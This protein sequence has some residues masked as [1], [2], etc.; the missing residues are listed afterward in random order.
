MNNINRPQ[1]DFLCYN[2]NVKKSR[3]VKY[4]TWFCDTETMTEANCKGD[5]SPVLIICNCLETDEWKTFIDINTYMEWLLNIGKYDRYTIFFHNLAFDGY[6]VIYWLVANKV[7]FDSCIN[8]TSTIFSIKVGCKLTFKCTLNYLGRTMSI[9]RLGEMFN[10]PKGEFDYNLIRRYQTLDEVPNKLIVYCRR[11]IEIMKKG[12]LTFKELYSNSEKLTLG[13]TS[14]NNFI[15]MIG[16]ISFKEN[17]KNKFFMGKWVNGKFIKDQ[18]LMSAWRN[19]YAGGLVVINPDYIN[20]VV[21]KEMKHYDA[22]SMYPSQMKLKWLPCGSLSDSPLSGCRQFVFHLI[23]YSKFKLRNRNYIPHIRDPKRST[24]SAVYLSQYDGDIQQLVLTDEEYKEIMLSYDGNFTIIRSWY[25]KCNQLLKEYIEY[26]E[27]VKN[28][29]VPGSPQYQSA[30]DMMNSL[31]GKFAENPVKIMKEVN[32][33]GFNRYGGVAFIKDVEEKSFALDNSYLPLAIAIASLGRCELVRN[34]RKL[35]DAGNTYLYCDTDSIIYIPN[36][37]SNDIIKVGKNF[38][39]WK[40]ER[41]NNKIVKF[42][43]IRPKCYMY[44]LDNGE[45]IIKISGVPDESKYDIVD[46][47]KVYKI[48]FDNF[49]SGLVLEKRNKMLIKGG[50]VIVNVNFT[51]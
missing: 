27:N 14:F 43:A 48:N 39:E 32:R 11:D 21:N 26:W 2:D 4:F 44:Q 3:Q 29:S 46:G 7:D 17:Y 41:P 47:K 16:P 38:G 6:A 24:K 23:E 36:G 9:K 19:G 33:E 50:V 30:K 1:G 51:I 12:Y 45:M 22:I 20:R 31:Y 34:I 8:Y 49:K 37:K 13:S 5:A 25:A 28:N 18:K 40:D 42:K 10:F 15:N 35:V